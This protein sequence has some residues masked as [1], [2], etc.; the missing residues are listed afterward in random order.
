MMKRPLKDKLQDEEYLSS[1]SERRRRELLVCGKLL[2]EEELEYFSSID[3]AYKIARSRY[4]RSRFD[5]EMASKILERGHV[6]IFF[7]DKILNEE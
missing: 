1:L 7:K 4:I 6:P 2:T 3:T 5:E